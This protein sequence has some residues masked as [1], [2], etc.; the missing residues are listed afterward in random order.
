LKEPITDFDKAY[1]KE[2]RKKTSIIATGVFAFLAFCGLILYLS[3]P[4]NMPGT[5]NI[6]GIITSATQVDTEEGKTPAVVI[7][8]NTGEEITLIAKE[9]L[10]FK[11]DATVS[12]K[13]V[14]STAGIDSYQ[15]INYLQ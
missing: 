3:L 1:L 10:T 9:G 2:K 4:E 11:P 5:E 14:R 12:L 15:F 13:K 7:R 6:Q 8:L